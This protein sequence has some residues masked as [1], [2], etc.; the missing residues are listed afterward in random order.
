MTMEIASIYDKEG[1]KLDL[2]VYVT[3]GRAFK[4]LAV[5]NKE[6]GEC[7][8][9]SKK[10]K[11][12]SAHHLIPKRLNTVNPFLEELRFRICSECHSSIHLENYLMKLVNKL[13]QSLVDVAG[14]DIA[15][16]GT[17]KEAVEIIKQFEKKREIIIE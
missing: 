16:V 6:V 10:T 7:P 9:C 13:C 2:D 3:K 11:N 4:Y 17:Y 5:S 1:H 15:S 8:I 14:V 12:M